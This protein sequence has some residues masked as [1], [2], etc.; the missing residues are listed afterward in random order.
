[1]KKKAI[2]YIR[3]STDEQTNGY[4]PADQEERLV[5][6]CDKCDIDIVKICNEDESAKDFD[7]RPEWQNILEFIKKNKNTVDI[8]LF[9]KWDRFSRNIAEAYITIKQLKKYNVEPQ[10]MEQPLDF[11]VPESKIMLAVY[12]AAPEVDNDR[13]ALNT[14]NGMRKAKKEGR[15]ISA[16]IKGYKMK[17]DERNKPIMVLEGGLMEE[18]VRKAF[19]EFATGLYTIED[20]RRQLNKEGLKVSRTCFPDLLRNRAYIGQIFVPTYKDESAYWVKAMH[21]PLIDEQT[22]YEVQDILIGRKKALPTKYITQR[23][24]L[25]LRGH[26]GCPK[27]GR[28]LTGSASTGRNGKFYY[29][30]C[31]KGCKE[32]LKAIE[33][34]NFFISVFEKLRFHKEDITLLGEIMKQE[35]KSNSKTSKTEILKINTEIEKQQTRLKNARVLMLDGEFT[36]SEYKQMKTDIEEEIQ[37]LSRQLAQFKTSEL[38]SEEEIDFCVS[39]LSNID[40]IYNTADIELK[41]QLIGSV[42]PENLIYE[43]KKYRT[44][45]IE[46]AVALLCLSGKDWGVGK[47][48]KHPIFEVLSLDV[49]TKGLEPPPLR[50]RS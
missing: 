31:N 35:L 28:N 6:Y 49:R 16:A 43:N 2:L 1:M 34:N 22:F 50:T 38:N 19:T 30:H 23:D 47:K 18:L 29:Y 33:Q 3:V 46:D 21:E 25:P 24:E 12:L 5:K 4:S 32:R 17:R 11:G 45:K 13:R 42:F 39:L 37:S 14:F 15:W 36:A 9:T 27:C 48:E 41:Q 26:L 44:A 20:I 10:A 40:Q 7:S 8:I